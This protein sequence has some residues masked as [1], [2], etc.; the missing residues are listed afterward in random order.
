M[1]GFGHP[2]LTLGAATLAAGAAARW[3]RPWIDRLAA[4]VDLRVLLIGSLLPDIIDKPLGML[5]MAGTFSSG[6]IFAH[7]LI[8]LV[9]L[10]AAGWYLYRRRHRTWLL[11]L[12]FGTFTHFI[13]DQMWRS[14][15]TLLWPAF[16]L[17]FSR[18]D[19]SDWLP[20]IF[21]NL[22]TDPSVYVP[23]LAGLIVLVWFAWLVLR[24]HKAWAFLRHG[25]IA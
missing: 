25:K 18:T 19:I 4:K 13:F 24:R 3:Q 9:L 6:R 8:F 14:P 10:A 23:E 17:G 21:H 22:F 1:L 5:F 15:G 12:A 11:A 16:G 20:H 7:T 2:G